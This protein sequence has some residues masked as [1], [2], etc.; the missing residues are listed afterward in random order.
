[1]SDLGEAFMSNKWDQLLGRASLP[2]SV[3]SVVNAVKSV[4]KPAPAVP[5]PAPVSTPAASNETKTATTGTTQEQAIAQA[6]AAKLAKI[7]EE[8]AK[9]DAEVNE[10]LGD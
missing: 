5:G 4:V 6:K 10:L 8:Q 7:K 3:K 9:L 2:S 1:M